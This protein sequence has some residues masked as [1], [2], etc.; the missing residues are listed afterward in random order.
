M[1][2]QPQRPHLFVVDGDSG[3][4]DEDLVPILSNE[5]A[6]LEV[7]VKQRSEIAALKREAAKMAAVDPQAD[8]IEDVLEYWRDRTIRNKKTTKLPVDGKRWRMVKARL[9]EGYEPDD[10][11]RAIDTVANFPWMAYGDRYADPAPGR[12]KRN[13]LAHAI[14]DE[15][16]TERNLNLAVNRGAVESY[17]W[18]LHVLTQEK[19]WMVHALA[20][21]GEHDWVHGE[22]LANAVRWA[23]EG[24][25]H[26]DGIYP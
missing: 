5:A 23:A 11:K 7:V 14:G 16:R 19:P 13:D 3:Q 9:K 1:S 18:Y 12:V 10:L 4:V 17:R 20:I 15:E 24:S 2:A 25:R 26:A 22:V 8:T 21:L 6:L